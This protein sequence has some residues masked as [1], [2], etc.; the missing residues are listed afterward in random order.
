MMPS[1]IPVILRF[2][3]CC[4][5]VSGLSVSV[6]DAD[7]HFLLIEA[8]PALPPWVTPECSDHRVWI[9]QGRCHVITLAHHPGAYS[10]LLA[11]DVRGEEE[12][13]IGRRRC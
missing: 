13:L 4:R 2:L 10:C 7:G 11:I 8:A 5:C 3:T 12:V 1:Y 9:R 6:V